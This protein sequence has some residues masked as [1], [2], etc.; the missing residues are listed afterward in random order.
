MTFQPDR[1]RPF[2]GREIQ[3]AQWQVAVSG[4][5]VSGTIK[6]LCYGIER[7]LCAIR[8]GQGATDFRPMASSPKKQFIQT[9]YSIMP[10]QAEEIWTKPT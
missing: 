6:G 3:K 1:V 5:E 2:A 4:C 7:C 9:R 8:T 10:N